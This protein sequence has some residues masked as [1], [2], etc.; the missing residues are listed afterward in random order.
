MDA[1][2]TKEMK[3]AYDEF[4]LDNDLCPDCGAILP[5]NEMVCDHCGK[6]WSHPKES[7]T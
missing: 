1:D 3:Q 7:E 2:K 5:I 4:M 6:D